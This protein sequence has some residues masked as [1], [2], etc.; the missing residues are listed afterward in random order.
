[1]ALSAK[2]TLRS[3]AIGLTAL[4]ACAAIP[5][6]AEVVSVDLAASG[7]GLVTRDTVNKRDWLDLTRTRGLSINAAR[8]ATR[9]GG[10]YAGFRIARLNELVDFYAQAVGP[11]PISPNGNTPIFDFSAAERAAQQRFVNL[12][13]VTFSFDFDSVVPGAGVRNDAIGLLRTSAGTG[14]PALVAGGLFYYFEN[15]SNAS[16]SWFNDGY[17]GSQDYSDSSTGVYLV[18]GIGGVPEP[19][20]WAMLIGGFGLIGVGLRRQKRRSTA[21]A[22]LAA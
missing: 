12:I 20:T 6:S 19:S 4:A 2:Y 22:A 7:D 21:V 18:R 8:A 1:M 9:P 13:G 17:A 11:V 14:D 16:Y 5:A 15:G 10:A 3:A